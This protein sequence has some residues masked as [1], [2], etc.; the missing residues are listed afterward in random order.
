MTQNNA[1]TLRAR[2][3][4]ARSAIPE[5]DRDR[6]GLLMRARLFTWLG[7]T[8]DFME[9]EGMPPPVRV[10]AYWAIRGEPDLLPLLEQWD[11][12]GVEVLLPVVA[13]KSEPL[14][15]HRWHADDIMTAGAFGVMEPPRRAPV[16]PDV[17]LVPTLGFTKAADRL[18]YG[19]GYYDRSINALTESGHR[20][21]TIGIAWNQCDI[22]RFEPGYRP[23]PHD[24]RLD[25][26]LTPDGWV[27]K[28]PD[29][30]E[31]VNP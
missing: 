26:V 1:Q 15:F 21:V 29:Y 7:I 19:Q 5:A 13:T 6:G 3:L 10:A 25:A 23:Q 31:L 20:P 22:T 11:E 27:P 12:A 16:K 2:L 4:A 24:Q 9:S 18:G 28:E 17:I 14:E 30:I 8:R